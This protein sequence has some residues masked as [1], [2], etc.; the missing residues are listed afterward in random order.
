MRRHSAD[1]VEQRVE[2]RIY[3]KDDNVSFSKEYPLNYGMFLAVAIAT[4]CIISN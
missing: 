3:K 2:R 4:L 1:S